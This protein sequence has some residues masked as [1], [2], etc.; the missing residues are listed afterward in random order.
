MRLLSNTTFLIAVLATAVG[1]GGKTPLQPPPPGPKIEL[2]CPTAIIRDATIPQGTD[3]HFDAPS[4][5]G[6]REPFSV[7]CDPGSSSIFPVGET[8]VR[9]TAT[10]ADMGQASCSFPVIVRGASQT[11]AKT[12]FMAFGDSITDGKVSL[13]PLISLAGP[14]TYPFKLEQML[15]QRYPTQTVEV[16]NR[17]LSGERSDRGAQRLPGVLEADKPEV[18]LILEGVNAVWLLTTSRQA[19]AIRSMIQSAKQRNVDPIVATVMPVGP[20]WEADHPG[21][22]SRIRALNDRIKQLAAELETGP[23]V[24]LFEV[25][26]SNKNLLGADDLHP[27]VEGQTRIAE[28][29]RD[30]IVRRYDNKSTM[31]FR[32][33]STRRTP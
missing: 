3:V 30:E 15:Q 2:A 21:S 22:M 10:D 33:Y 5:T 28:A 25:F 14:D 8:S 23:V 19:D 29:F 9:C 27:T 31:S 32:F 20:K 7:Q 12:K 26:E 11:I 13:V 18:V 16:M 1:C 6:G 4:P 17:G 24:D